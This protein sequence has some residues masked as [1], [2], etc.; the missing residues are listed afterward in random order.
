M[1]KIAILTA[2]LALFGFSASAQHACK[3]NCCGK[4]QTMATTTETKNVACSKCGKTTCD[5][6]CMASSD[7]TSLVCKL[8]SE[9][10]MKRSEELKA[11]VFN[12]YEKLN[13]TADAVE[14]V[15]SDSKKYAPMLVEFINSE[16]DCCPF[17]AFDLKFLSN[18]D[19]VSLTIGGSPK[20]KEMIKTLIN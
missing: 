1:K 10:Q 19:K 6:K 2:M 12:K 8:T 16:R 3:G 15:Y 17:F 5:T 14:L 9:Q 7:T 20:I 4:K 11:T 18:S 13:E